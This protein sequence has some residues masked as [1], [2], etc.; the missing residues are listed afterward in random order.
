MGRD[1]VWAF[2]KS[3]NIARDTTLCLA[4]ITQLFAAIYATTVNFSFGLSS[5]YSG[6]PNGIARALLY[7]FGMLPFPF[8]VMRQALVGTRA[9]PLGMT[10]ND[11]AAIKAIMDGPHRVPA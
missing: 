5:A 7:S 1:P 9:A 10:G 6:S 3:R 4:T 2:R 8:Q 11:R